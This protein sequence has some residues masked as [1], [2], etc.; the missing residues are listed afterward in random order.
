MSVRSVYVWYMRVKRLK[1]KKKWDRMVIM[2][3]GTGGNYYFCM[4]LRLGRG[5][6]RFGLV[7]VF[8]AS[9]LLPT[10]Q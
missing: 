9:S 7:V 2:Q 1:R 3:E 4:R 8:S 5:D 6:C 10:R